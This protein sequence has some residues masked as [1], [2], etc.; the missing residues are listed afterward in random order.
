MYM[1]IYIYIYIY[2]ERERERERGFAKDCLG[3]D[4]DSVATRSSGAEI[5]R[6]R[7]D[8]VFIKGGCSRRGVQWMGVISY[9][10]TAHNIM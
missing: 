1:Y 7:T 3:E 4:P 6:G 2:R 10:K 8:W 9:N 5:L